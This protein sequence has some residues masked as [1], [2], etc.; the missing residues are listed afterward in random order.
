MW[1]L[2]R[3]VQDIIGFYHSLLVGFLVY[4]GLENNMELVEY[5]YAM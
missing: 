1:R 4:L 5:G 2:Y 3:I